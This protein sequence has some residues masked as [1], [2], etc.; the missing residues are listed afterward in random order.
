MRIPAQPLL[1][2]AAIGAAIV[3]GLAGAPQARAQDAV[4][5]E[6][7]R[8]TMFMNGGVSKADEA[9]MRKAG[10]D[11]NLRIEF[12]ERKDNEFVADADLTIT[13]LQGMP[14]FV[15]SD[16]GPIVNLNLPDGQYRVAATFHGQT[17]VQHVT[18]KGRT[19]Q[20]LYFH[21]KGRAKV[22][23]YDGRPMGGKQIPG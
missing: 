13:D 7:V 21:W 15:L 20:D 6:T 2:H 16:A 12:S 11:F 9:Y 8:T 4:V 19:G 22:D 17:E 18:V 14:V 5:L 23:P 10:R 3:A 1:K